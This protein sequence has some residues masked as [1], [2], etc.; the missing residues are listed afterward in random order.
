MADEINPRTGKP[1]ST[2]PRAVSARKKRALL[3]SAESQAREEAQRGAQTRDITKTPG[4]KGEPTYTDDNYESPGQKLEKEGKY[5]DDGTL[6][7]KGNRNLN[8]LKI[9]QS[10]TQKGRAALSIMGGAWKFYRAVD[11]AFKGV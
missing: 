5:I 3:K 1:Y 11:R 7:E 9:L 2:N 6:D 8:Q 4:Y 10:V